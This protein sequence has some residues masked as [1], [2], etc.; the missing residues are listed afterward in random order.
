MAVETHKLW[1]RTL[2]DGAIAIDNEDGVFMLTVENDSAV[3]GTISGDYPALNGVA[4]GNIYIEEGESF[5]L[6]MPNGS[7]VTG[8]TITAPSGCTL[9]IIAVI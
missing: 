3:S 5:S 1:T 9:K 6:Q 7:V 2:T 4:N 8:L